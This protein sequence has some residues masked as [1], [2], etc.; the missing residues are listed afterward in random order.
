M[1]KVRIVNKKRW[2]HLHSYQF[3]HLL[4]AWIAFASASLRAFPH[5][6]LQDPLLFSPCGAPLTSH[7]GDFWSPGL[8]HT[9]SMLHSVPLS[10]QGL[11]LEW[12]CN[13]VLVW[14]RQNQKVPS[15][16]FCLCHNLIV[17][18]YLIFLLLFSL[19]SLTHSR[20]HII[21]SFTSHFS[22]GCQF[23]FFLVQPFHRAQ[24]GRTDIFHFV[25]E[26]LPFPTL[27]SFLVWWP[28]F[29]C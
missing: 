23:W 14:H 4:S 2:K 9:C 18:R 21:C 27:Y 6:A 25:W 17:R 26:L 10:W 11:N 28:H 7:E 22:V 8:A 19:L 20:S 15:P 13:C 5:S 3:I 16:F 1:K 24:M 12:L 29:G